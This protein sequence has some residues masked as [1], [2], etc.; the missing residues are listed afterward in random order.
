MDRPILKANP[1]FQQI[2][3]ICE[4]YMESLDTDLPLKDGK[5]YIYEVALIALYGEDVFDWI[6]EQDEE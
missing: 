6:N 2:V 1:N 4:Q 5:Y 3:E